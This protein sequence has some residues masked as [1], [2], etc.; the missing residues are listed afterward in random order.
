MGFEIERKFLVKNDLWR[1][2]SPGKKFYQGYLSTIPQRTVRIRL[3]G[4]KGY[5]TI[6]GISR[7]ACRIEYE[8]PI[9]IADARDMLDKLCEKPIIEKIRHPIRYKGNIWEVDEFFGENQG[10][11]VAE[12]ELTHEDQ[13]FEKPEWIGQEVT[14]DSKYFNSNLVHHPFSKWQNDS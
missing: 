4:K 6:K 10:L 5:L 12:L 13:S 8:Y 11:I 14:Q 2:S 7:G 3:D 9:P 1:V